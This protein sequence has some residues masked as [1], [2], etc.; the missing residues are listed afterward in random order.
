MDEHRVRHLIAGGEN[1]GLEFK[2][3]LRWDTVEKA[4][5]KNLEGV[6]VKCLAGFLNTGGGTL[7]MGVDD[8][9]SAIGLAGDYGSLKGRSRDAFEL[10][11]QNVVA[12]DLGEALS[13]S[14]LTVN[15]HKID[16]EDICQ[17]TVDPSDQPVYVDNS[18]RALFYVRS[19]NLTRALL[20][21]RQ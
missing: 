15:F 1:K 10:H 7:L 5:N 6:V 13:A 21:T 11:L 16:G 17:V 3:S 8:G 4:V 19:G 20:S 14:Y 18:N 12:R 9:P 2:S